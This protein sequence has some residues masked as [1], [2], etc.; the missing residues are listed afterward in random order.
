MKVKVVMFAVARD[1]IGEN[2]VEL[3]LSDPAT[4]GALKKELVVQYPSLKEIVQRS[5]FSVN[6]EYAIDNCELTESAEVALIPPVSG[7]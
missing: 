4:V 6:H 7:G 5:A 2:S 1:M 3:E